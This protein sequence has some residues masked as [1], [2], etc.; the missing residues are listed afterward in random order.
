MLN[1]SGFVSFVL[2][3][4]ADLVCVVAWLN[5]AG[6]PDGAEMTWT[7]VFYGAAFLALL[8]AVFGA[9]LTATFSFEKLD[10]AA[11]TAV[12]MGPA[13]HLLALVVSGF[14][15]NIV[16]VTILLVLT[17]VASVVAAWSAGPRGERPQPDAA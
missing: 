1:K 8:C 16:L 9:I 11:L 10:R 7:L 3:F 15:P 12:M 13:A 2:A 5:F 14:I 6:A 4:L 17:T